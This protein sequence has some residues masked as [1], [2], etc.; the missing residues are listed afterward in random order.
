[1]SFGIPRKGVDMMRYSYNEHSSNESPEIN[2]SPLVDMVF[3][4]LIFFI[5]TTV[6][7][8]ETGVEVQKPKA[9]SAQSLEKKSILLALTTDGRIVYG[10]REVRLSGLRGLISRLLREQE[11]PV[12]ILADEQSRSGVLVDV[13]DECKL[14]GAKQV[15]IAAERE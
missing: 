9:A 3:L 6:F 10:G 8:E 5:V 15:S 1:M 12:I 2:I 4:L 7:V 13:I 11:M 14:A